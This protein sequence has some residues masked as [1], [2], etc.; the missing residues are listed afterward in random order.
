MKTTKKA[1]LLALCAVL[2]VVSTVF[3]TLAYLTSET[4]VVKNTFT[5]GSVAIT[6]DEAKVDV[7]GENA[8]GRT[9]TGNEY[10]LIPGHK[11]IKDPTVYV[12]A[13]SEKCYVFVEVVNNITAIEADTT[14][15]AQM[16]GLDWIQMT[17]TNVW[18]YENVVDP[19]AENAD[20]KLEVF[21]T[22]TIKGDANVAGYVT[23]TNAN[24]YITVKAYAVQK[25]GFNTAQ[26]AWTATFGA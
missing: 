5:A 21:K 24:S 18:Y 8:N 9:T 16:A 22:F 26:A 7:Y 4:Q 6:L 19:S 12:D 10:K 25:D 13:I 11:Y 17:G 2:L 23:A 20:L 14:I 1:L 3:A 15:A